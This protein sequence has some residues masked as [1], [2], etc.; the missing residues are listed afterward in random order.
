M[1]H[2]VARKNNREQRKVRVKKKI[3]GTTDMPRLSIFRSNKYIYAQIIDDSKGATLASA[4]SR[5][6]KGIK[7]KTKVEEAFEVGKEIGKKALEEKIKSVVYDRSG[8]KYHGRVKA[9]ADGA[10]KG[11]LRL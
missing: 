9:V 6:L 5:D 2:V 7:G 10:R 11:G 1:Y 3:L 8:Y 4:D